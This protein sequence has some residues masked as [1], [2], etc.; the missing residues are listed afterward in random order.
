MKPTA[1]FLICHMGIAFRGKQNRTPAKT[2]T[3]EWQ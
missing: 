2:L 1:G 3:G